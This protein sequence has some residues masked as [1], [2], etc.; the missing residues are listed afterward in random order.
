[1]TSRTSNAA[2]DAPARIIARGHA[3]KMT[4]SVVDIV[5]RVR[6]SH[7]AVTVSS[8]FCLYRH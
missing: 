1:M 6:F 8:P 3:R 5:K 2:A 7:R 4:G